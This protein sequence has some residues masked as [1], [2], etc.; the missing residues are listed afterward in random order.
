MNTNLPSKIS[1]LSLPEKI[2]LV[3]DLWDD[4]AAHPERLAV[5][6][7]Q[8]AELD[9]RKARHQNNPQSASHWEDVKKKFSGTLEKA[10]D[11]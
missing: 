6:E 7:W 3:E 2:Q 8:K 10:G 1:Q 4:I 9:Q 11:F 5:P